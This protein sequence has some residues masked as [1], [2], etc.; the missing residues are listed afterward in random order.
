MSAT[1]TPVLL[2]LPARAVARRQPR[3]PVG[4]G[5]RMGAAFPIAGGPRGLAPKVR[6]WADM[7]GYWMALI[8]YPRTRILDGLRARI[9]EYPSLRARILDGGYARILDGPDPVS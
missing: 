7:L 4:G 6:E 8:Q 3:A 9:V 2:A 1:K 5:P